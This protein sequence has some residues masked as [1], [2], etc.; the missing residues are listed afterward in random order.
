MKCILL[1]IIQLHTCT[2]FS[3]TVFLLQ[4]CEFQKGASWFD[5]SRINCCVKVPLKRK[6]IYV[7][8]SFKCRWGSA[9]LTKLKVLHYARSQPGCCRQLLATPTHVVHIHQLMIKSSKCNASQSKLY[10]YHVCILCI[11]LWY[12]LSEKKW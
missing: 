9:P 7:I 11:L 10:N 1:C 5:S 3:T 8:K 2:L 6:T 4:G 12:Y